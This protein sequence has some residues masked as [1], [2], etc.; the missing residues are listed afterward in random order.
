MDFFAKE[1]I[2]VS[3]IV[4]EHFKILNV[5]HGCLLF[6]EFLPVGIHE[7][8]E[9]KFI[10]LELWRLELE[11]QS[12]QHRF[13]F[14]PFIPSIIALRVLTGTSS[15]VSTPRF[16]IYK[17]LFYVVKSLNIPFHY[18]VVWRADEARSKQ[19]ETGHFWVHHKETWGCTSG[20]K[21]EGS[22]KGAGEATILGQNTLC[23]WI[24]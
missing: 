17:I 13:W 5:W 19:L 2:L 6:L 18:R 24:I 8:F 3:R 10:L 1:L 21:E 16:R 4:K 22:T 20:S 14:D 15:T 11:R 23:Y 12:W 9:K 7:I